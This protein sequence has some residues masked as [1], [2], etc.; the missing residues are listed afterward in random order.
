MRIQ[1]QKHGKLSEQDRLDLA[2]LLVKAGY[3]V[4]IGREKA[5]GKTT[6]MAYVEAL[7][8]DR[9]VVPPKRDENPRVVV[10]IEEA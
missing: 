1:E 3:I 2:S 9:P 7:E 10:E 4:R 5:P 8:P 6:S